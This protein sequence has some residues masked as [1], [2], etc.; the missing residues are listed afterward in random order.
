MLVIGYLSYLLQIANLVVA[1]SIDI[2]VNAHSTLKM[3]STQT[4]TYIHMYVYN[5]VYYI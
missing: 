3:I 4:H 5:T 2:L 1:I